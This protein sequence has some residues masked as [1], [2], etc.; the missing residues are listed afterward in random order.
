MP[1]GPRRNTTKGYDTYEVVSALQKAVRRGQEVA[2]MY[3]FEEL[4]GSG[5]F[6]WAASRLEV[7]SQEDIGLAD[8]YTVT[9]T[10]LTM[11]QARR[12]YKLK[13]PEWRIAIGNA[14]RA[15]CRSPKSR[16]GDHFQAAVRLKHRSERLPIPDE[17]LDKHTC[18][19]KKMG[20]GLEHFRA[21]ASRLVPAPAQE[22][23]YEE[24]AYRFWRLEEKEKH[25]LLKGDI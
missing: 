12:W 24:D 9:Y 22:D 20:R 25:P 4:A 21:E 6:S 3:W 5:L 18:R 17:A 10:A 19:G 23:R 14:I 15:L 13:K 16:E 11:E 1:H 8:I 7:I 2:A